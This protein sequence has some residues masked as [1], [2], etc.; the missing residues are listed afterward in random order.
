MTK[1]IAPS[2]AFAIAVLPRRTVRQAPAGVDAIAGTRIVLD[3]TTDASELVTPDLAR[4]DDDG[5]RRG[6][7]PRQIDIRTR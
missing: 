7:T 3:E 1:K 6:Q 4:L 5:G 2:H